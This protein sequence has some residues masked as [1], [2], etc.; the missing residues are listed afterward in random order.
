MSLTESLSLPQCNEMNSLRRCLLLV[1]ITIALCALLISAATEFGISSTT[2]DTPAN[3]EAINST[4]PAPGGTEAGVS[5]SI[6]STSE[7]AA[8]TESPEVATFTMQPQLVQPQRGE[9]DF[10]V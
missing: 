6:G 1:F 7:S 5:T 3:V 10:G 2:T 4:T 8:P 9:L